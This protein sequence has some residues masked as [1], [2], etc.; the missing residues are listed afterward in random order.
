MV[1]NNHDSL[2]LLDSN[3]LMSIAQTNINLSKE[4]DLLFEAYTLVVPSFVLVELEKLKQKGGKRRIEANF[5]IKLANHI[6]KELLV[7]CPYPLSVDKCLVD[8]ATQFK[9][10][11]VATNDQ[12]LRKILRASHIKTIFIRGNRKLAIR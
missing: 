7:P 8:L 6:A 9:K 10:C 2:I 4:L 3:F 5:A 12:P 1:V 11:F